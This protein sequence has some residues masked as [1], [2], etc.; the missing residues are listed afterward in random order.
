MNGWNDFFYFFII[1]VTVLLSA[2][3]LWLIVI[4]PEIDRVS[5][6]FFRSL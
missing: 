5:K 1:G 6:R 2:L 4:T 3:G